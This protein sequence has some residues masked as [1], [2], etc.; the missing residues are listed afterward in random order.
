MIHGTDVSRAILAV[1]E[2]A[3]RAAGQRWLITDMRV[4]DWWDL[5]S[6]WGSNHNIT[7]SGHGSGGGRHHRH[8]APNSSS[9][10]QISTATADSTAKTITDTSIT[11][12][13]PEST[14]QETPSRDPHAQWVLELMVEAGIRSVPRDVGLLGRAIDSREFWT[15]FGITPVRAR[16]E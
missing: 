6:A 10:P 5:A 4:Y 7:Y 1:Y 11:S 16:L 13:P 8:T 14:T 9:T 2:H 15:T 12:G 3:D